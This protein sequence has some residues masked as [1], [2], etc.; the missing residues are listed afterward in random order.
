MVIDHNTVTDTYIIEC[1]KCN[2][3]WEFEGYEVELQP[4]PH[5]TCPKCRN[6]WIPLF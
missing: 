2:T 4:W 3:Q 5:V 1:D 6:H